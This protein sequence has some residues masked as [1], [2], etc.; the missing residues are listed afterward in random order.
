M[1]QILLSEAITEGIRVRAVATYIPG[2]SSPARDQFVFAYRITIANV[3]LKRARLLSR[4]WV[5]INGNGDREDVEGPGVIGKTPT[6]ASGEV[7][8]Y[9]SF[10]PLNTEWGTMEGTYH[11]ERED[12]KQFEVVIPR[13]YLAM[14]APKVEELV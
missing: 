3:G 12:G 4:H 8:E 2:Q 6:L 10:C 11:M 7:F 13:F 1:A 9:T 14:N 5:I